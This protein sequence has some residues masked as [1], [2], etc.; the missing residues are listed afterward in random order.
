MEMSLWSGMRVPLIPPPDVIA[1]LKE[2]I[3]GIILRAYPEMD[4]AKDAL[5]DN[6]TFR[7]VIFLLMFCVSRKISCTNE[8]L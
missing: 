8:C 3:T 5:S 2:L 1:D 6:K 4:K 7:F